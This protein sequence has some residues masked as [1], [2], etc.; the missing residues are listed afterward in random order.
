[1]NRV[2]VLL[3]TAA[4]A[5]YAPFAP[6]TVGS[7][8]GVA[9]YFLTRHWSLSAQAA[10]AVAA[11][12]AGVW[13]A[14]VAAR[15]FQREDPSQV[16]IDEVAGQLVTFAFTGVSV[17]GIAIGF[18]VFRIL[19][20]IKPWP[21]GRLESLPHGVGIVADDVMAGLYGNLLLQI[22]IRTLPGVL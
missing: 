7:A 21:C 4:G 20:V 5:G 14:G 6:G 12:V 10:L 2:A 13:A 16:V 17:G 9:I 19:D 8:V 3:A 15:H 22:L 11:I 18:V 1:M